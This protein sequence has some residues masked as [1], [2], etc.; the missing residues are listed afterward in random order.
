MGWADTTKAAGEG[1]GGEGGGE[2]R[3][4]TGCGDGR[5]RAR[6]RGG[7]DERELAGTFDGEVEGRRGASGGRCVDEWGWRGSRGMPY[8][9]GGVEE[10]M[11]EGGGRDQRTCLR[12]KE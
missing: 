11:V 7:F 10:G 5:W 2:G 1:G 8:C 9:G 4:G 3:K 12:V 6:L